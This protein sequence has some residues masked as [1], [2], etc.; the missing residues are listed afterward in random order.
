MKT[1]KGVIA[2][3]LILW[4]HNAVADAVS[5]YVKSDSSS[6]FSLM[7]YA[8]SVAAITALTC[9]DDK[10]SI[11][12]HSLFGIFLLV[13]LCWIGLSFFIIHPDYSLL[14]LIFGIIGFSTGKALIAIAKTRGKTIKNQPILAVFLIIVAV[15]A[16]LSLIDIRG[17]S[18]SYKVI[19]GFVK[20]EPLRSTIT[21]R[22]TSFTASFT[23]PVAVKIILHSVELKEMLSNQTCTLS[24]D[25]TGYVVEPSGRFAFTSNDCPYMPEGEPYDMLLSIKYNSTIDGI[26]TTHTETGHIKGAA[27]AL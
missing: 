5:F 3:L 27:E 4:S 6:V 1:K 25:M 18:G 10:K 8:I 14:I 20:I 19:T 12:P 17:N 24:A 23:N 21:Y 22:N 15:L 11:N 7:I 16:Q 2:I 26:T 13:S 9:R